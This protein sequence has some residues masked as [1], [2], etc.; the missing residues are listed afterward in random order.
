V[1]A[2]SSDGQFSFLMG[3]SNDSLDGHTNLGQYDYFVSKFNSAG[4][5][6]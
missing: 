4:A 6:Q 5:L 3:F 1:A 2:K